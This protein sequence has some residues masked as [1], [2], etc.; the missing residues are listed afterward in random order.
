[1]SRASPSSGRRRA[2]VDYVPL[3]ADRITHAGLVLT[4]RPVEAAFRPSDS[5][6][7]QARAVIA[8]EVLPKS[9]II[10][11]SSTRVRPATGMPT[12]M[13]SEPLR[14]ARRT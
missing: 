8:P 7:V 1:M 13:S 4:T 11:S 9:P 3:T 2:T 5:L 10:G 14:P 12:Q 6:G